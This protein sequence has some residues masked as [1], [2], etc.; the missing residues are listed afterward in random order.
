[1]GESVVRRRP[2]NQTADRQSICFTA[3]YLTLS[4]QRNGPVRWRH[5]YAC[6]GDI[7]L[8]RNNNR[9]RNN[10]KLYSI[11]EEEN[12]ASATV[13]ASSLTALSSYM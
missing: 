1:M 3:G 5:S 4:P 12:V 10:N 7:P 13:R 11:R 8:I 9:N 2:N 6:D